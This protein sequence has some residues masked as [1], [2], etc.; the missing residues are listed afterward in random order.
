MLTTTFRIACLV[1][2]MFII[3]GC[4]KDNNNPTYIP[5]GYYSGSFIFNGDT[6]FD[7]I[8]FET[9]SFCE[10]PSG[11]VIHQKF[12]CLVGGV[13]SIQEKDIEFSILKYP[14]IS[15][16]ST[17]DSDI[18]L[19]GVYEMVITGDRLEFW[20]GDETQYQKYKLEKIESSR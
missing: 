8:V 17:C 12:P 6:V 15:D 3:A 4:I 11:G 2:M 20:K 19:S 10:V 18:F 1:L 7:A 9:D 5:D 14:V 13:Y 16:T